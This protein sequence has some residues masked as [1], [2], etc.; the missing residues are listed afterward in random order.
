MKHLS[1]LIIIS[2]ICSLSFAQQN[3]SDKERMTQ[4]RTAYAAAVEN[5]RRTCLSDEET[6]YVPKN[7]IKTTILHNIAGSGPSTETIEFFFEDD[8]NEDS[9]WYDSRLQFVRRTEIYTIAELREYE[10]FLFDSD[11]KPMFYFSSFPDEVD[12]KDMLIEIRSYYEDGMIFNTIFKSGENSSSMKQR[13]VPDGYMVLPTW[14]TNGFYRY[15][16]IFDVLL[17][18]REN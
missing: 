18:Y 2:L 14:G 5:A 12:D 9:G 3:K 1:L 10:E 17:N 11:G 15:K 4:I 8:F 16:N 13:D 7:Y 6:D